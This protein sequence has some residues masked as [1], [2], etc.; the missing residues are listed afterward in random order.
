LR[1]CVSRVSRQDAK[2]AKEQ[3]GEGMASNNLHELAES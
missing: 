1:L 2:Y 3:T